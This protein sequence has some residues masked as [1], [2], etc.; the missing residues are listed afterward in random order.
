MDSEQAA[1]F[2][3]YVT[4]LIDGAPLPVWAPQRA[5]LHYE[6]YSF[7]S[8]NFNQ[9][10]FA[11]LVAVG[12]LANAQGGTL[13]IIVDGARFWLSG[14]AYNQ[15]AAGMVSIGFLTDEQEP[16]AMIAGYLSNQAPA[17][18]TQPNAMD[19][20]W[21]DFGPAGMNFAMCGGASFNPPQQINI[22]G[23]PGLNGPWISGTLF[24]SVAY[25]V[26]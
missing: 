13:G 26:E 21:V 6:T 3:G 17:A 20:G 4:E 14:D 25:H 5:A 2:Q 12:N 18:V 23:G 16:F 19:S 9:G 11:Q 8:P 10:N 1:I 22:S 7:A 15:V 24:V